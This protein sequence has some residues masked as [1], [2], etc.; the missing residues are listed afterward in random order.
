MIRQPPRATPTD[1]RFPY[2]TLFRST[3]PELAAEDGCGTPETGRR[4]M[5]KITAKA[6]GKSPSNPLVWTAR[7]APPYA[8]RND[9]K[10]RSRRKMIRAK[11]R[12]SEEHTSELQ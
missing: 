12:R 8:S 10:E 6:T 9:K 11:P 3:P 7:P 5:Q 2:P 4:A 1:T